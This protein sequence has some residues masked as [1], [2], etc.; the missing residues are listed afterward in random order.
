MDLAMAYHD[1]H[2]VPPKFSL[3]DPERGETV[4]AKSN[5]LFFDPSGLSMT[6]K[7]P[8]RV[9]GGF[10]RPGSLGQRIAAIRKAWG[11]TQSDLADRLR[12][13]KA[14]VSAWERE[15]AAPNG[16]S[17]IALAA[18]L[19]TSPDALLGEA[20]F[21]IPPG[22]EGVAEG[23]WRSV[24][25]PEPADPETVLLVDAGSATEAL[26]PSQLKTKATEALGARRPVWL[27]V[28]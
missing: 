10:T 11:W 24:Q 5:P 3:L 16:I 12:V 20:R 21:T 28:G 26:R 15:T 22:L 8:Y 7:G 2:G 9:D 19:N 27:V 14:T 18:V 17:L 4:G 23:S 13:R 1:P 6:R 25:L